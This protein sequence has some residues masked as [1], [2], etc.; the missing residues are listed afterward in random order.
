MRK[1][2]GKTRGNLGR[3]D[4]S[5]YEIVNKAAG[6]WN[7]LPIFR[8]VSVSIVRYPAHV[9]SVQPAVSGEERNRN[10]PVTF[11]R[12]MQSMVGDRLKARYQ[13]PKKL[14][15]ELFVLMLQLK[16]REHSAKKAAGQKA[17]PAKIKPR[18]A[19]AASL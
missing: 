10:D 12:I 19:V 16:D 14:S 13:P 8:L 18:R 4:C 1:R 7:K 9:M 3:S 6:A 11:H 5:G 17:K 2:G 15:H